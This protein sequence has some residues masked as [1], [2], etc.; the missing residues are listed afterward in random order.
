[1]KEVYR[2]VEF[3]ANAAIIVVAIS[4]VVGLALRYFEN[5]PAAAANPSQ[6][7]IVNG[8]KINLSGMDWSRSDKTLVLAFSTKCK[9]C[10]ES[11]DFYKRLAEQQT[12]RE[13]I[14]LVVVGSQPI[15]ELKS[16]FQKRSIPINEVI[17][18]QLSDISVTGTPTILLVGKDGEV[19]DSWIGRL[20]P[21]AEAE[22]L[23]KVF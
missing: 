5:P 4:L 21:E 3:A 14:R 13:D 20:P 10:L 18:A 12:K 22:L 16:Y 8:T 15:E 11:T 2:K 19:K 6:N 7:K 17:P 23:A 1:M 9:F